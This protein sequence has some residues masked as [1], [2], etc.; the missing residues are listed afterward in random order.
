MIPELRK[1]I[2]NIGKTIPGL[3]GRF[4]FT[5]APRNVEYPY[6]VFSQVANTNSRDTASQF[7]DIFININFYDESAA[8]AESISDAGKVVFDDSESAFSAELTD[9][10]LDRI[11]RQLT[12]DQKLD[13]VFMVSLQ[14]KLELTVHGSEVL[15]QIE[16]IIIDGSIRV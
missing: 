4:Y 7:E 15:P 2:F 12:R 8:G 16:E 5:E 1:A 14:Y 9:N 6:A 10:F 13:D 11:E 3:S